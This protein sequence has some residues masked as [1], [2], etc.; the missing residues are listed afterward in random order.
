M[1]ISI[2]NYTWGSDVILFGSHLG[3]FL[4]VLYFDTEGVAF[5]LIW[6][7]GGNGYLD[8]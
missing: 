8:I 3:R 5:Y 6:N 7:Y 4:N 1:G 2:Q